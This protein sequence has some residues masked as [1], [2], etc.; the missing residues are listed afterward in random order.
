ML[1]LRGALPFSRN[2]P[3]LDGLQAIM[4]RCVDYM[5]MDVLGMLLR[6][7]GK[8][9]GREGESHALRFTKGPALSWPL[10]K[11]E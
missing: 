9:G 1:S 5:D 4:T 2:G 11:H 3:G 6:K 7:E 8:F 10:A